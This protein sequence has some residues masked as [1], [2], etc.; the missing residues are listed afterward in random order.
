MATRPWEAGR[1]LDA[2]RA[3]G[4]AHAVEYAAIQQQRI[5]LIWQYNAWYAIGFATSMATFWLLAFMSLTVASLPL[6][7]AAAMIASCVMWFAYR[8]VL[9]IDRGVVALY[10]RIVFLEL[11][12]GLDFYRDYLRRRPRGDTERSYIEKCEQIDVDDTAAL[13]REVYSHFN[14]KDFPSDRRITRHFRSAAFL[15]VAMYWI[16]LAIIVLPQYLWGGR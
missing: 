14:A 1:R 6:L 2:V 13:W 3:D 4:P 10:P 8:V 7:V 12:L 15:L 5:S 9:T 16:V 11:V